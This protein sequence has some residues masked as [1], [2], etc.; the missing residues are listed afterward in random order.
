MRA[1]RAT[2]IGTIVKTVSGNGLSA[3]TVYQNGA[4]QTVDTQTE[5]L[6]YDANGDGDQSD[7]VLQVYDTATGL[8]HNTH[9]AATRTVRGTPHMRSASDIAS[10]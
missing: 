6:T 7:D 10:P 1:S 3:T 2:G 5:T 4:G 8:L 9:Q